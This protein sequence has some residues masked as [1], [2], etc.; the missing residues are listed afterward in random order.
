M[1][2]GAEAVS[3]TRGTS[4]ISASPRDASLGHS[5]VLK[6]PKCVCQKDVGKKKGRLRALL[7]N[8]PCGLG[9]AVER[10]WVSRFTVEDEKREL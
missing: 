7:L 6:G 10:L 4:R 9:D 5:R 8:W 1:A 3:E 2:G